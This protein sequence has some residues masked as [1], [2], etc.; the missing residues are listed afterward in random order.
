MDALPKI[1]T[2][3]AIPIEVDLA[4][5]TVPIFQRIGARGNGTT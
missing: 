5:E 4:E 3:A 1:R 2:A